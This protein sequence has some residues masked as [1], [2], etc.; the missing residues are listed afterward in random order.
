MIKFTR[1]I[2]STKIGYIK[3]SKHKLAK[4]LTERILSMC[5]E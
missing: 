2:S 5:D 1:S 3:V 4:E